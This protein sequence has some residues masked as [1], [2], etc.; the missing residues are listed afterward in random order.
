MK[1]FNENMPF[2]KI[3]TTHLAMLIPQLANDG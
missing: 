3:N 1:E 2:H